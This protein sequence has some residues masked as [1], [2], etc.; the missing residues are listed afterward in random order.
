MTKAKRTKAQKDDGDHQGLHSIGFSAQGKAKNAIWRRKSPILHQHVGLIITSPL[1]GR[2]KPGRGTILKSVS[3]MSRFPQH[4]T[5]RYP[6][7]KP[8]WKRHPP[9]DDENA[10]GE[11]L[12]EMTAADV[13]HN[14]YTVLP[15]TNHKPYRFRT[16]LRFTSDREGLRE[17]CK[18]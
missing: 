1:S 4:R 8:G 18:P 9:D 3:F 17:L 12:R 5:R 16:I 13:K 10:K 6:D 15:F 14:G 7:T 11:I 2:A